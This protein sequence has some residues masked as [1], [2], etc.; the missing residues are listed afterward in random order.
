MSRAK[1]IDFATYKKVHKLSVNGFNHW[2]MDLC[3]SIYD[4]GV[5]YATQD[6]VASL[7][8]EHLMEILLS[9]K[10]IGKNRAEQVVKRILDEGITYG[11]KT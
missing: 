1:P 3:G 5:R 10:G 6:C 4:D 7:T 11:I 8:E 9:V 2:L